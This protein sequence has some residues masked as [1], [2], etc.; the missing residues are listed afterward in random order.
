MKLCIGLLGMHDLVGRDFSAVHELVSIADAKGIDQLS[1]TD[2]VVMGTH[3]DAYPYGD[4]AGSP[5]TQ[6]LDP[7]V[8]LGSFASVT[9]RIRLSS[10][11]VISPLRAAP[12]LA[13]QI[14]TLDVLSRGRVTIGLGTGWQR[15]EYDAC[16]VPW[17]SRFAILEEQIRAC[18]ALWSGSAVSF[19]G[20]HVRFDDVTARPAPVQGAGLPI[21]LGVA[22]LKRNV[23]RIAELCDGWTPM[24]RDPAVLRPEIDKLRRAFEERGRDPETLEVRTTYEVMKG[25]DGRPDLAATLA[26]TASYAAAGVTMVRLEPRVFCNGPEDFETFLDRA[27]E[28][29]NAVTK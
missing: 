11:I 26:Q 12:V 2:H 29:R 10:G 13:K 21:L 20:E 6:F 22:L 27:I 5:R 23:E 3:L 14:A 7:L 17:E 19:H 9:S 18:K 15:E 28:A 16:G 25:S 8:Y 4:F 1:V 24:E